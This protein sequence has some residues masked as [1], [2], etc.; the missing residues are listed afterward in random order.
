MDEQRV[1][2]SAWISA[3]ESWVPELGLHGRA[4]V[5]GLPER[6]WAL[7]ARLVVTPAPA[8]HLGVC[9]LPRKHANPLTPRFDLQAGAFPEGL[10]DV[11]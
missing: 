5:Q 3:E 6:T 4:G 2:T 10:T 8:G 1:S 7:T 11:S 9:L